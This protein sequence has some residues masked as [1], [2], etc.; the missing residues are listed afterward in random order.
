MR[1][2]ECRHTAAGRQ[3]PPLPELPPRTSRQPG[4]PRA[5]RS[6]TKLPRPPSRRGARRRQVS[7]VSL[8]RDSVPRGLRA[9]GG[10][11]RPRARLPQP[12]LRAPAAAH[13]FSTLRILWRTPALEEADRLPPPPLPSAGRFSMVVTTWFGGAGGG[14]CSCCCGGSGGIIAAEAAARRRSEPSRAHRAPARSPGTRKGPGRAAAAREAV[15]PAKRRG[16][17]VPAATA[18]AAAA[19]P[20]THSSPV[21]VRAPFLRRRLLPPR[22]FQ[23]RSPSPGTPREVAAKGAARGRRAAR[24]L[25]RAP[26]RE[27]MGL[28][29][30][31]SLPA[32]R[33]SPGE[34]R[35]CA[36]TASTCPPLAR[37]AA[38]CVSRSERPRVNPESRAGAPRRRRRR[39]GARAGTRALRLRQRA[40]PR[41]IIAA[42]LLSPVHRGPA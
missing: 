24:R 8:G 4:R 36:G 22:L 7:S 29:A 21:L 35:S 25:G 11:A 23:S 9:A 19:Q 3:T 15:L 6:G 30:L 27:G 17:E 20:A 28:R 1:G 32:P 38:V 14:G 26:G 5:A 34:R 2:C 41:R 39:R 31:P 18:A 16:R 37:K 12:S 10:P 13:L 33:S 42:T 40:L